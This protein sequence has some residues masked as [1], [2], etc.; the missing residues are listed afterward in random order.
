M[1]GHVYSISKENAKDMLLR[2]S[3]SMI[4]MVIVKHYNFVSKWLPNTNIKVTLDLHTDTAQYKIQ[5]W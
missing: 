5:L 4:K 3:F 2:D 1:Y